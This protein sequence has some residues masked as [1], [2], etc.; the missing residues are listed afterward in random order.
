MSILLLKVSWNEAEFVLECPLY[1]SIGDRF[2]SLF[3]IVVLGNLMS[4]FQLN[5][6]VNN[7]IS[8][9]ASWS[10]E[11]IL[12]HFIKVQGP[13]NLGWKEKKN[14]LNPHWIWKDL[15]HMILC[16][17]DLDQDLAF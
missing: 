3:Q 14:F 12:F 7:H 6:L 11:L 15:G 10:F 1:N 13:L 4:F 8:L 2:L 17:V 5:H 16:K 9:L